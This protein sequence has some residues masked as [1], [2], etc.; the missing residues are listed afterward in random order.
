MSMAGGFG[1]IRAGEALLDFAKE[2]LPQTHVEHVDI[3]DID[4]PL[5][6]YSKLYDI[7]SKKSP[8]L[9]EIIYKFPPM[10]FVFRELI[11][12]RKL[13][14][15]AILDYINGKKPDVLIFTNVIM[16]P[17]FAVAC[18]KML[19]HSTLVVVVTDYHGHSYYRFSCI[20]YYFVA[21]VSVAK[22]LETA[23]IEKEKIMV[24]GIPVNP[25]FYVKENIH[26]LK[27]KYCINNDFPVV[28]CITSF[29]ASKHHLVTM[30]KSLLEFKQKINVVCLTN[31]NKEFYETLKNNFSG[32]KRFLLENWTNTIEEYI[33]ISDVVISK[34]GGLTVSECLALQKPLIMVNPIP[35]QEE[36]NAA[37]VEEN[38]FGVRVNNMNEVSTVLPAMM[39][40][41]KHN[42]MALL[43]QE[44][45]C[46]KI[47]QY[48]LK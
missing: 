47:F 28:V 8:L 13:F 45:P 32:N 15:H 41:S 43:P 42:Q 10:F 35:G 44:N 21:T 37:F 30:V 36:Y 26:D 27:S 1:H 12:T 20:D 24:T 5:K 33:K 46:E 9:W 17:M 25:R 3:A 14:N 19:P 23:G 29:R 39:V 22:D 16:L 6:K 2:H 7:I 18:K 38:N 4:P 48:I 40:L 11:A 34:A 31:G